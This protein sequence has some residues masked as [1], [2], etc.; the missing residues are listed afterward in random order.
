M[1]EIDARG[2]SCP[3]PVMMLKKALDSKPDGCVVLVD[4][5]TS[6]EN[7]RKFAQNAG[8]TVAEKEQDGEYALTCTK[9]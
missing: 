1:M 8:Y 5:K 2:L 6:K 3:Q 7:V 9:A 4:N